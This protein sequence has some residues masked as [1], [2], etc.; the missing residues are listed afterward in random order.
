MQRLSVGRQIFYH[1]IWPETVGALWSG[2]GLGV[3]GRDGGGRPG[4]SCQAMKTP[5]S[6]SL[7]MRTA[8]QRGLPN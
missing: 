6:L 1:S 3:R 5:L 4:G 7:A 8:W 2:D